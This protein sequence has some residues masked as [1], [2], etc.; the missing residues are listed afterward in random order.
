MASRKLLA[1]ATSMAL[2][3]A[4]TFT[5]CACATST[6]ATDVPAK[7]V[8]PTTQSRAELRQAVMTALDGTPVTLAD[9]ALTREST[10]SIERQ[11]ARDS[12]GQRI[13]AREVNRPEL[14]RLVKHGSECVLI[15]ERTQSRTA[16]KT[17]RC[18]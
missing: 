17:A 15:H 11:P 2:T 4:L 16:L 6:Q 5:M 8:A 18:E 14:F 12:N 10:L 1:R 3:F 13:D 9:D 7:I